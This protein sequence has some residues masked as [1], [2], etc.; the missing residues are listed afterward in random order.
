MN[1]TGIRRAVHSPVALESETSAHT[2][3]GNPAALTIGAI[4]VVYGDIGTSPLYDGEGG[5]SVS[6]S[7]RMSSAVSKAKLGRRRSICR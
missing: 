6:W 5:V 1:V 7:S 2:P 4:G 3:R